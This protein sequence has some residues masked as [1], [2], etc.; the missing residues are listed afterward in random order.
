MKHI[1]KSA[2]ADG[3]SA[4][5]VSAEMMKLKEKSS[6]FNFLGVSTNTGFNIKRKLES[7]C[8]SMGILVEQ[9]GY[10]FNVVPSDT[11]LSDT[12]I[13]L[14]LALLLIMGN[15]KLPCESLAFIDNTAFVGDLSLS[16]DVY[17][18][19]NALSIALSLKELG[20]ERIVLPIGNAKE[21][22]LLR[23]E[24]IYFMNHLSDIMH[25]DRIKK[26]SDIV[27]D[28]ND[29]EIDP[30]VPID[31]NQVFGHQQAKRAILI[32]VA[33]RHNL[34]LYGPP[35][36]GK[37][38]LARRI[39]S[40]MS[41]LSEK[42]TIETTRIYSSASLLKD[43]MPIID[44]P[45]RSPHHSISSQ[46]II[47][48]GIPIYPGEV[49]LAHNG[50]LFLDEVLE[51]PKKS[52]E[53]LRECLEERRIHIKRGNQ[54]IIYPAS[55][56]VICALNP[57][58][59]GYYGVQMKKC[60][61][62]LQRVKNYLNKLSGPLLDRIEMQV[63]VESFDRSS[64]D[65]SNPL[66]S[67]EMREL[68]FKSEERQFRRN[69]NRIYN[70]YLSSDIINSCSMTKEAQLFLDEC[71][72]TMGYS[73]RGYHKII[74]VAQTIADIE[75]SDTISIHHIK[76]VVEYKKFDMLMRRFNVI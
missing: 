73:T 43:G 22:A 34:M 35:G 53:G 32:A 6:S 8:F 1:I 39:P 38:M 66:S 51:F 75:E 46:G 17:P 40:I 36:S 21:C 69:G 67:K 58:P 12:G 71:S 3:I 5:I 19:K 65:K 59:C 52:L 42:E 64:C 41:R 10:L 25:I 72:D 24:N 57:C 11:S 13:D 28:T 33:G 74:K 54:N 30:S 9:C 20:V 47:G 68:V 26:T 56:L 15:E 50:V 76:E 44:P 48:G 16:G 27:F 61:C 7:I 29:E 4:Y 49:S 45:F 55:S 62:S 60:Q 37:S 14:A 70:G 2:R 23:N 31:F 18:I 63:H